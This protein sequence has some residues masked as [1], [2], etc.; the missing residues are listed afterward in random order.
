MKAV[1]G[2]LFV[3]VFTHKNRPGSHSLHGRK[4]FPIEFRFFYVGNDFPYVS[5]DEICI[6]QGDVCTNNVPGSIIEQKL[7]S[8]GDYKRTLQNDEE[9]IATLLANQLNSETSAGRTYEQKR[10]WGNEEIE[11][12]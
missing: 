4:P 8:P 5:G 9:D 11:D 2:I 12:A 3:S 6:S 7:G 10:A 1:K